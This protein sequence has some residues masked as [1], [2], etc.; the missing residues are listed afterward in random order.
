MRFVLNNSLI[1]GQLRYQLYLW[2]EKE[3]D[4]LRELCNYTTSEPV[5]ASDLDAQEA[6]PIESIEKPTLHEILIQE[7]L[8]FEAKVQR[9]AKRK[10]W[11]K[12]YFEIA[13]C[14]K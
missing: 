13:C 6:D 7:K 8:D 4:A 9:A 1:G 12:G 5:D 11:L 10:K 14:L 3:V 2:L